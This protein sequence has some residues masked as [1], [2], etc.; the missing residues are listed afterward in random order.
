ML[1]CRHGLVVPTIFSQL[2]TPPPDLLIHNKTESRAIKR[3]FITTRSAGPAAR[4]VRHLIRDTMRGVANGLLRFSFPLS[5]GEGLLV[6]ST[7][8][9]PSIRTYAS[10]NSEI[11]SK[12]EMKNS[13]KLS[14][15][16]ISPPS[17]A[18]YPYRHCAREYPQTPTEESSL[19]RHSSSLVYSD[20]LSTC[21]RRDKYQPLQRGVNVTGHFRMIVEGITQNVLVGGSL[22]ATSAVKVTEYLH[23]RL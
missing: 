10:L 9:T 11:S 13:D 16:Q 2:R 19:E 4:V 21:F 23:I 22:F 15:L 7:E 20:A 14:V 18:S 6:S 12:S 5:A 3:P 8:Y 1:F 17:S